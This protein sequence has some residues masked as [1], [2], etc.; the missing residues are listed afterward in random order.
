[1]MSIKGRKKKKHEGTNC[2]FRATCFTQSANRRRSSAETHETNPEKIEREKKKKLCVL[3]RLSGVGFVALPPCTTE[4]C[5][6]ACLPCPSKEAK[7][8]PQPSHLTAAETR[9]GQCTPGR[10]LARC[11][12]PF[13]QYLHP[14]TTPVRPPCTRL[15]LA[16][17]RAPRSDALV[18]NEDATNVLVGAARAEQVAARGDEDKASLLKLVEQQREHHCAHGCGRGLEL[19]GRTGGNGQQQSIKDERTPRCRSDRIHNHATPT[20][21]LRRNGVPPQTPPSFH[22]RTVLGNAPAGLPLVVLRRKGGVLQERLCEAG[23]Q[24][25]RK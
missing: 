15:H 5:A 13:P 8:T 1:M 18:E 25:K 16:G 22:P 4:H 6:C 10:P 23:K 9:R 21:H 24:K 14:L 3:P 12:P 7:P 17:C 11:E 19:H 20:R 2:D